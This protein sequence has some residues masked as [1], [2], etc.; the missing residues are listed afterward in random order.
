MQLWKSWKLLIGAGTPCTI[1][2]IMLW[3]LPW[4]LSI[5][6]PRQ[7]WFLIKETT[8]L[9]LITW[10]QAIHKIH[11]MLILHFTLVV[12]GMVLTPTKRFQ[13]K[14]VESEQFTMILIKDMLSILFATLSII[15]KVALL[16]SSDIWLVCI[17]CIMLMIIELVKPESIAGTKWT[18]INA[19]YTQIIAIAQRT[20]EQSWVIARILLGVTI[21][22]LVNIIKQNGNWATQLSPTM[23]LP[24]QRSRIHRALAESVKPRA[25]K[26]LLTN[27]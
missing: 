9:C 20:K 12:I 10:R 4:S 25:L 16:T 3:F 7:V 26:I 17:I 24:A 1:W 5:Q 18:I 13:V 2:D 6:S 22:R 8:L 27:T 19:V 15:T 11:R 21:S 14:Q 23:R